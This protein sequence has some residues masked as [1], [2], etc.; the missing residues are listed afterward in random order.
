MHYNGSSIIF[1][2]SILLITLLFLMGRS[3]CSLIPH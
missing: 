2:Q 3:R 1:F